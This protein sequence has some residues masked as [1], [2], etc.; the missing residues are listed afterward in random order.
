MILLLGAAPALR[1]DGV[2][3]LVLLVLVFGAG[4]LV[5]QFLE[6]GL[7]VND[8]ISRSCSY[9]K[10]KGGSDRVPFAYLVEPEVAST[11]SRI[12]RC[13]VDGRDP[14]GSHL[15]PRLVL[16]PLLAGLLPLEQRV[17]LVDGLTLIDQLHVHG[18]LE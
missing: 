15:L 8:D 7:R 3:V 18:A 14:V 6:V 11:E 5:L 1:G 4:G 10:S 13:A 12:A 16:V 2:Q 9:P 17:D